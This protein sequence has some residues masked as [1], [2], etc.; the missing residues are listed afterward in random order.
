M[1]R[2]R[3]AAHELRAVGVMLGCCS[4]SF[5]PAQADCHV[6]FAGG[7]H[8]ARSAAMV[9]AAAAAA[10]RRGIRSGC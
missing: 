1:R 5:R 8:D 3:R 9:A 10:S 2:P 6:L 7:I 4:R